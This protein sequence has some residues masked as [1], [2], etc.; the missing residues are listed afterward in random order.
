MVATVAMA[1]L[2][3]E[4]LTTDVLATRRLDE[5]TRPLWRRV[6]TSASHTA[7]TQRLANQRVS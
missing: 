4:G 6:V 7:T 5:E 2:V 1:G 3:T